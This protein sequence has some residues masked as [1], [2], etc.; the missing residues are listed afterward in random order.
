MPARLEVCEGESDALCVLH[1]WS[2]R[3]SEVNHPGLH[4]RGKHLV[5][6]SEIAEIPLAQGAPPQGASSDAETSGHLWRRCNPAIAVVNVLWT[7]IGSVFDPSDLEW[8]NTAMLSRTVSVI[9][10]CFGLDPYNELKRQIIRNVSN[11][12][13]RN[14]HDV[15]MDF[16]ASLEHGVQ[17]VPHFFLRHHQIQPTSPA[18]SQSSSPCACRRLWARRVPH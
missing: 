2:S 12:T 14:G 17:H 7:S 9:S 10:S 6:K 8:A 15:T 16:V 13:W 5:E 1:R 11:G 3:R 18:S 4:P